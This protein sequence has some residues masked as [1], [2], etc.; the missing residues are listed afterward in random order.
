[1]K[2]YLKTFALLFIISSLPILLANIYDIS[3]FKAQSEGLKIET[4][5][6]ND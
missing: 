2:H 5:K 3:R 6:L 1:M 4:R